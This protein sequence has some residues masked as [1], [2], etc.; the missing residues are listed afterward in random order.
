M[1]QELHVEY[2]K[3]INELAFSNSKK[4]YNNN[5]RGKKQAHFRYCSA[6]F[7]LYSFYQW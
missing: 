5:I 4:I 1:L 2:K 3:N 6:D 7:F